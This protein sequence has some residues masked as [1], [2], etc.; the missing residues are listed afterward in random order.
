[1]KASIKNVPVLAHVWV[2]VTF[3]EINTSCNENQVFGEE[4]G[5]NAST[6]PPLT[7]QLRQKQKINL[8]GQLWSQ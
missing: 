1:M 7:A 6:K 5:F 2:S 3:I 4:S 8:K